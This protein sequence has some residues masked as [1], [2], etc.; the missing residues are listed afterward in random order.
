M[1][2]APWIRESIQ[3]SEASHLCSSHTHDC[4]KLTTAMY[5]ST[6]SSVTVPVFVHVIYRIM[7]QMVD[8]MTEYLRTHAEMYSK[9]LT[10]RNSLKCSSY[11]CDILL[12][13]EMDEFSVCLP[14][15]NFNLISYSCSTGLLPTVNMSYKQISFSSCFY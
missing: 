13:T 2:G 6:N 10:S 3:A 8:T 1:K 7:V 4:Q 12:T 5:C 14:T 11:S 15:F 9:L